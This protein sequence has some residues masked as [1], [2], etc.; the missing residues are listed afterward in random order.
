MSEPAR[1]AISDDPADFLTGPTGGES[2]RTEGGTNK[3]GGVSVFGSS[4]TG[5]GEPVA[6]TDEETGA[7][8]QNSGS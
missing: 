6:T 8:S 4:R 7:V 1:R 2:A 3:E 5:G